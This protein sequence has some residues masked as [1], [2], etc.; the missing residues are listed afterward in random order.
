MHAGRHTCRHACP[1]GHPTT[2][3]TWHL[4]LLREIFHAL[5]SSSRK[6]DYMALALCPHPSCTLY[7][8][9]SIACM[10]NV[11]MAGCMICASQTCR[12]AAQQLHSGAARPSAKQAVR[13]CLLGRPPV[14][15]PSRRL[16]R[17]RASDGESMPN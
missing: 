9:K 4:L 1:V 11:E 7:P 5:L 13:P 16:A 12:S 6:L 3:A 2:A 17:L 15:A 14:S 8:C 10:Q